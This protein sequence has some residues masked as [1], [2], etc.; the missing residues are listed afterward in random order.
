M[1]ELTYRGQ[2]YCKETEAK[3]FTRWWNSV[4]APHIWLKYRGIKYRPC[5]VG[6]SV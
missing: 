2:K 4:H 5:Q 6:G 1:T 3:A